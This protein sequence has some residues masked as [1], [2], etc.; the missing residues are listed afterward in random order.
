MGNTSEAKANVRKLAKVLGNRFHGHGKGKHREG[1]HFRK[2]LETYAAALSVFRC[3]TFADTATVS[4]VDG[5]DN[6]A[7]G[8]KEKEWDTSRLRSLGNCRQQSLRMRTDPGV[9]HAVRP[10]EPSRAR[11][12][13]ERARKANGPVAIDSKTGRAWFVMPYPED[14]PPAPFPAGRKLVRHLP[15]DRPLGEAMEAV[16]TGCYRVERKTGNLGSILLTQDTSTSVTSSRKRFRPASCHRVSPSPATNG[17]IAWAWFSVG[18]RLE[19]SAWGST[20][21]RRPKPGMLLPWT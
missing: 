19:N 2:E 3:C 8:T 17:S 10:F 1:S 21:H 13:H 6:R 18:A 9:S 15:Q 14:P 4:T 12:P 5:A 20:V 16:Q 11:L 7:D